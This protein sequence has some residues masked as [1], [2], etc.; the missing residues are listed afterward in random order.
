M[1]GYTALHYILHDPTWTRFEPDWVNA[2]GLPLRL[3]T[4]LSWHWEQ[5][6]ILMLPV[7]YYRMT[8][9]RGGR[10][11]RWINRWDWRIPWALVGVGMHAGILVL[12][13]VGPFSWISMAYYVTLWSGS[14]WDRAL[15]RLY[16]TTKTPRAAEQR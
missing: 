1:G 13:N 10:L 3:M 15:R 12:M 2:A 7:L 8:S 5:L 9:L 16:E 14:E 6:S 11:R 4:A